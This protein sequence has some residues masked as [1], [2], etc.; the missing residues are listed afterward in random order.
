MSGR[1]YRS[2]IAVKTLCDRL[3][4]S[5]AHTVDWRY[6]RLVPESVSVRAVIANL[7]DNGFQ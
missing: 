7:T 2:F 6:C 5:R 1:F 4:P 3:V